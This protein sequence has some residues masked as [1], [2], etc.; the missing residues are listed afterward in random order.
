MSKTD[1]SLKKVPM[2]LEAAGISSEEM[3]KILDVQKE[4]GNEK[5]YAAEIAFDLGIMTQERKQT[6]LKNQAVFRAQAAK[7]DYTALSEGTLSP[8]ALPAPF[9]GREGVASPAFKSPNAIDAATSAAN[10]AAALVC[11]DAQGKDPEIAM[12]LE[13]AAKGVSALAN[14]GN[15]S[16]KDFAPLYAAFSKVAAKLPE[17]E[18]KLAV[19]YLKNRRLDIDNGAFGQ[20][21]SLQK[22]I[23]VQR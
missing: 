2:I 6:A 16:A 4:P 14:G 1:S 3:K 8:D 5:K 13:S 17:T 23:A 7:K 21:K 19:D 11:L 22:N 20:S 10:L 15:T 9:L 12:A 18:K